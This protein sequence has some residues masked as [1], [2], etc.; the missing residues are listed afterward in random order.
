MQGRCE[1][2][3]VAFQVANISEDVAVCHCQQC[4]RMSGHLW[5]SV[6]VKDQD[7]IF[8]EEKG[9]KWYKSSDKAKRGFCQNCGSSLFYRLTEDT[10][11][12]IAA[13]CFQNPTGFYMDRHIFVKDKGDYYQIADDAPQIA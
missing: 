12:A 4:R 10:G 5:A 2:G 8:T 13:G 6:R 3:Q 9:L 1:C 11:Y 7:M